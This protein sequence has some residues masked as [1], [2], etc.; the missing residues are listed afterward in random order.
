MLN[1]HVCWHIYAWNVCISFD[2]LAPYNRI[3]WCEMCETHILRIFLC[4]VNRTVIQLMYSGVTTHLIY[5]WHLLTVQCLCWTGGWMS[6]SIYFCQL[7]HKQAIWFI[8]LL[9]F[10]F[11][12]EMRETP[13]KGLFSYKNKFL[14]LKKSTEIFWL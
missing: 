8:F 14:R 6:C 1:V 4:F 12:G 9:R 2:Q 11:W 5:S 13:F 10:I 3:V 7:P